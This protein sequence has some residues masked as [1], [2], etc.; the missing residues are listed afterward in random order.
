MKIA[1]SFFLALCLIKKVYAQDIINPPKVL[2]DTSFLKNA[3]VIK[4]EE[5][6]LLEIT[7][8][9]RYTY[10]VHKVLTVLNENGKGALAFVQDTYKFLSL[11]EADI[12]V[13]DANGKQI[14]H[15]KKRDMVTI[16]N[17]D[18]LIEDGNYTYY[19]VAA[20]KFP[21]TVEYN[22]KLKS[23]GTTSYPSYN[24]I[25]YGEAVEKS[26]FTV[27]VLKELDIRY[28]EENIELK[29]IVTEDGKYKQYQ[30]AVS[31]LKSLEFEEGAALYKS[32]S[33]NIAPNKFSFYGNEGDLTSWKKFGEWLGNLYNGLDELPQ[34]RKDFFI[35]LV[36]N[37][38]TDREKAKIIYE[39][40]Q[41]NFRYVSI[42]LGIGGLKP[43]SADFTD[44]KKYGDCKGLSN[45]MKAALKA[46][47]INGY[48][49]II[50]SY[51]NSE[52]VDPIFPKFG[53]NHVILCIPQQKD[54]IWLECTSNTADFNVLG[55]FTENRNALLVTEDGGKLVPTPKSKSADN[56]FTA[57]TVAELAEDGSGN[58][59]LILQVT[60]EYK[61]DMKHY[62][63]D[64]KK[65]DQKEFLM[66]GYSL[67]HPDD[68]IVEK[69]EAASQ[70][71]AT[72]KLA[73][74]KIPEFIAG[75][76]MFIAPRL[77]KQWSW[78]LPK[79]E[80]RRSDFYFH[81]PF[82]KTDTTEYKLPEGFVM[83][84]LPSPK[85]LTCEYGTYVTKYW[86]DANKKSIYSTARLELTQLKI[87]A[88]KYA[89]VK[90]FFDEVLKED[91]QRIV[92]KKQ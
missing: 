80:N 34:E 23:S 22:Y 74:E 38:S 65:D 18:G 81:N 11:D 52:P 57:K 71:G 10:T 29:P 42:Q 2:G 49:A 73:M 88:A 87:P 86:F 76:K 51:Y 9:D 37:A 12:K 8:I 24:V 45:Y 54:S 44:K 39:Y 89:S 3:S 46:V 21:I 35:N 30:W 82:I 66:N 77:Y 79:A 13:Y 83:D 84:A 61:D 19:E 92:I 27:R 15:Y 40:L 36:K 58:P 1:L 75:N 17:G 67:K 78:K 91:S 33:I 26:A 70:F 62:L 14:G 6:I 41:K 85:S 64:E 68:F 7:D 90:N 31:N 48:V 59:L 72:I 53:F 32:P 56:I 4:R 43:F 60:G 20:S 25:A 50:N 69:N 5:D 63:F 28:R 55:T 47:G 16:A